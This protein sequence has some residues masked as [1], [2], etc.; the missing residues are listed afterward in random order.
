MATDPQ[1]GIARRLGWAGHPLLGPVLGI[2][3]VGLGVAAL[4]L[5]IHADDQNSSST[6]GAATGAC[7]VPQIAENV[8]PSVVTIS[9]S[10]TGG[11]GTGSGEVIDD[12][13]NILTNNHVISAAASGGTIGVIFSDGHTQSATLVG[14]DPLTDLA[15]IR[16]SDTKG[17]TPITFGPSEQ[18]RVGES[19]VALGAPL[20]LSSTVT[21][22][23]VS[24]RDRSV[25]VPSDNGS[26][27]L[28]VAAIQTD[29]AINPGNSGGALVDCTG[30]LIGIPTAGA[31]VPNA[32][33]GSSAGSIGLGF[34]IPSDFGRSIADSLIDTGKASHGFFGINVTTVTNGNAIGLYVVAVTPGGPSAQAGLREGDVI[35]SING[36]AAT[37][38]E[39]LLTLT[40]TKR[41]G[42][43]VTMTYERDGAH[44]DATITLGST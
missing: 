6:S 41:A 43:K 18:V 21:A 12:H 23:V 16:V 30:K 39:Q 27:A 8:L 32:S 38:A 11:S 15:V 26:T 42:D 4:V 22:G 14:R 35:V 33:G 34:A 7:D 36:E 2:I 13:G 5:A 40:L 9:V 24:A 17:L 19:V 37:S 28:L 10:G 31:T 1:R 25:D 29:A 3:G 44:H 20:G